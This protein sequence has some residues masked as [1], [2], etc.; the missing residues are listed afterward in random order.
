MRDNALQA[1]WWPLEGCRDLAW[2]VV[3]AS[4]RLKIISW[5]RKGLR[6]ASFG[7]KTGV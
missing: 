5:N 6:Y 3:L 2:A 1:K 4:R 7:E